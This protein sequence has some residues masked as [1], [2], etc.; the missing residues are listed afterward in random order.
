M[1][2]WLLWAAVFFAAD[3]QRDMR[4]GDRL[5]LLLVITTFKLDYMSVSRLTKL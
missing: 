1:A 5:S 3:S 4:I 2:R